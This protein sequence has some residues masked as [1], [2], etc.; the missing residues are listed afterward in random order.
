MYFLRKIKSLGDT[1]VI[2]QYRDKI[3]VQI[4]QGDGRQC[5]IHFLLYKSV[6]Y[7]AE[8]ICQLKISTQKIVNGHQSLKRR[9]GRSPKKG[10]K[11]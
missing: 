2:F 6:V 10:K 8:I 5:L 11:K 7:R 1:I 4:H 9:S 3:T